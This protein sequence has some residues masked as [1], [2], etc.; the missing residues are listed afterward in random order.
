VQPPERYGEKLLSPDSTGE[1]PRLKALERIADDDTIR[2][3]GELQL[4]EGTRCLEIGAGAGS[5]A[6][7]L[8]GVVGPGNVT[9]TDVDTRFL[10]PLAQAGVNVVR[11]DVVTEPAPGDEFDLIHVRHVL[12]HLPSRDEVTKRL[13]SWLSVGGWLVVEAGLHLP[14]VAGHPAHARQKAARAHLLSSTIGTDL[15]TWPK[16]LPAPL[17]AAG[18]VDIQVQGSLRPCRGATESA[19]FD[20]LTLLSLSDNLVH[21]GLLTREE[22]DEALR[23]YGDPEFVDYSAG[24]VAAWG[25]RPS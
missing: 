7:W 8:A 15:T 21:S 16:T 13:A 11:H 25:R 2:W 22:V 14:E 24:V 19:D 4:G 3:L 23:L 10:A 18:L 1:L 20:R 12:E 17:T 5:V 9:A 6:S